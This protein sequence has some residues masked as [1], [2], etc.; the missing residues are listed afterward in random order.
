MMII[1]IDISGNNIVTA[2]VKFTRSATRRNPTSLIR[3]SF[4]PKHVKYSSEENETK[5]KW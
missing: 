4:I 3:S 1:I 2:S 5:H